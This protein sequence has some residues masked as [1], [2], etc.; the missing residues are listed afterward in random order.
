MSDTRHTNLDAE[1]EMALR[2]GLR[3]LPTPPLSADFDA[4]VLAA[5]AQPPSLG[6]ALR[7]GIVSTLRPFLCGAACSLALTLA[8]LFWTLHAPL[9]V[10]APSGAPH[11]ARPLDMAAVDAL[12]SRPDLGASSLS[13]WTRQSALSLPVLAP[14]LIRPDTERRPHADGRRAARPFPTL[15]TV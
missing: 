1:G 3:R 2:D 6:E 14:P 9:T 13:Q 11:M 5:L 15:L 4:R 12:L 10:P 8:A 7:M